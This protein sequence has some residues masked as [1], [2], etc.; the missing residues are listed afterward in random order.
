[1]IDRLSPR[2]LAEIDDAACKGRPWARVLR[3]FAEADGTLRLGWDH[4]RSDERIAGG[5]ALTIEEA[6]PAIDEA[7]R[8][9]VT[10]GLH[11]LGWRDDDGAGRWFMA[12]G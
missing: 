11:L 8:W 9:C 2:E 3:Q 10:H 5:L 7:A 4:G 1:M 12:V 6:R